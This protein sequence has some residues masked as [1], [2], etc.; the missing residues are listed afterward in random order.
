[1]KQSHSPFFRRLFALAAALTAVC[2][3]AAAAEP[4]PDTGKEYAY[5]PYSTYIYDYNGYYV[6]TPHAYLPGAQLD[7]DDLGAGALS[8]PSDIEYGPDNCLYLS[9]TGNNRILK[10][11]Q[12]RRLLKVIDR[13]EAPS[14]VTSLNAPEGLFVNG[15]NLYVADTGNARV[16]KL[17]HDGGFV[18]EIGAPQTTLLGKEFVYAPKALVADSIGNL[19]VVAKGVNMGLLRFDSSGKFVSFFAAQEATYSLI[20]YLWKPF[21]TE[22]QLERMEDFVPTEYNNVALDGDGFLYVTTNDLDLKTF[23]SSIKSKD[24]KAAPVKKI[25]PMGED[26]LVRKG[27]FAPAGDVNYGLDDTGNEAISI[28]A[29]VAVGENGMYTLLDTRL[30]RLFTYSANGE[31][32]YAFGDRGD[33]IGTTDSPSAVTY[34]GTDLLVLDKLGGTLTV[35]TR[36]EYGA[37]ISEVLNM[38]GDF[39]YEE[40]VEVWKQILSKNANFDIAYD[41]IASSYLNMGDYAKAMEYFGYSNNKSAYSDAYKESRNE[42]L[43]KYLVAVV[44]V[45]IAVL[46]LLIFVLRRIGRRNRDDRYRD[47][48]GRFSGHFLYGF[49]MMTHPFDGFYDMKHEARGSMGAATLWLFLGATGVVMNKVFTSYL[50]NTSYMQDVSIPWEYL[51]VVIPLLLWVVA[52]WCITTLVDGEGRMRDIYMFTGY[53]V[54]PVALLFLLCVPLSYALVQDESMYLTLIQNIA[55]IWSGFLLF[56]GNTTVHQY[57]GGKSVLAI[58]ISIL[59]IAIM[60]FVALLLITSYQKLFSVVVDI[61]KEIRY[62]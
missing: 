2:G 47:S 32:L 35:Y 16:L 58:V 43:R 60:I 53:A 50:F 36:T 27:Y 17:T 3:T 12:N 5:V 55:L 1:M 20:D 42:G 48:R 56:A 40:S 52:N 59:G 39:R 62:R 31:L 10:L 51:T 44:F 25:N 28:I 22:A 8:F 24:G 9:D 26:V 54:A 46:F 18:Q 41:G 4:A 13:V 15:E 23:L 6:Q 30:N 29:D 61:W 19:F 45:I 37:L 57:S 14:G 21:M 7:G 38:Y 11:D 49:Y 33:Q 34:Q